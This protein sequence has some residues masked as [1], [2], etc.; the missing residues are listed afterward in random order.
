MDM[1]R[2]YKSELV[3]RIYTKLQAAL[4][5]DVDADDEARCTRVTKAKDVDLSLIHISEP[6]RPY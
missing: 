3:H 2:A 4:I 5:D 6:T 1:A